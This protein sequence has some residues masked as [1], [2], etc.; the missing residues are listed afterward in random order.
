MKVFSIYTNNLFEQPILL[1]GREYDGVIILFSLYASK[2][3]HAD[4][5]MDYNKTSPFIFGIGIKYNGRGIFN[6]GR[7][8]CNSELPNRYLAVNFMQ[9]MT[10][11]S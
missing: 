5:E 8:I 2:Y 9:P 3:F 4:I 11:M 7:D 10:R 6:V 1:F